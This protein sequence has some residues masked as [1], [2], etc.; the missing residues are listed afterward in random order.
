M[1][2]KQLCTC[3]IILMG[4]FLFS[5]KS[6]KPILKIP[7]VNQREII[8]ANT[9][10]EF[11]G[12][13]HA[14]KNI[15]ENLYYKAD[16]DY[17]DG[18]NAINLEMEIQAKQGQYIWMNAKAMGFIN[19]ARVLFKP[20]S[21]R[22]IDLVNRKYISASYSYLRNFTQTPIQFE[23]LQ[24]LVWGNALFDPKAS[25][26]TIDSLNQYVSI[27][28][29]LGTSQQMSIHD[30][31]LKTQ[32]VSIT[33]QLKN[34][35]MTIKY[36]NFLIQGKNTFPQQVV[37]NIRGEKIIDCK[38]AFSNFATEIKRDAQFVVPRSYKVQIY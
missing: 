13:V 2:N 38:F 18:N 23:Q 10:E 7:V 35:K 31:H 22:I 15:S 17:N 28:F 29:Q 6:K 32:T 11:L 30:N 3:V 26:S 20:D 34:Q 8:R 24:N 36:S 33:E 19:V 37:I 4:A 5:C 1:G 21:I 9:V 14:S 12:Q 25:N 27:L 16:A